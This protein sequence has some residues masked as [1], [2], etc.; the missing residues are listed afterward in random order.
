MK[1]TFLPLLLAL[2]APALAYN[3]NAVDMAEPTPPSKVTI[4]STITTSRTVGTGADSTTTQ[5]TAAPVT[6]VQE[7][8]ATD[9]LPA[10]QK[11]DGANAQQTMKLLNRNFRALQRAGSIEEMTGPLHL[12]SAYADQAQV[13]GLGRDVPN[14]QQQVYVDELA[15]FRQE[16]AT[17]RGHVEAGDFD[18]AK[19]QLQVL[20]QLRQSGNKM[21][22]LE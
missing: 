10:P 7:A 17:L 1:K 6:A 5:E 3:D 19:A 11:Y 16:I 4:T 14:S 2:G 15:Q 8:V 22:R 13:L 12:L 9:K 20:D 18:A 21:F